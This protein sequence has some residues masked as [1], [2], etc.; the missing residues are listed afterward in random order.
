MLKILTLREGDK[1]DIRI[2]HEV[3]LRN[4]P[5]P[6]TVLTKLVNECIT[7]KKA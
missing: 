2:N 3:L 7:E 5:L 6:L 4:E 1:F